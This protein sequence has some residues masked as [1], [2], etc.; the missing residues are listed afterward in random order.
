M[1]ESLLQENPIRWDWIVKHGQQRHIA[2]HSLSRARDNTGGS[3]ARQNR[4]RGYYRVE[5]YGRDTREGT[6]LHAEA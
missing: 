3:L 1:K 4:L 6:S 2:W 5:R